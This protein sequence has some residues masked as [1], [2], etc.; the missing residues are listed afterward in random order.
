MMLQTVTTSYHRKSIV[1]CSQGD[2][3]RVFDERKIKSW[4]KKGTINFR[5]QV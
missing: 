1:F 2:V 3:G 4:K 5:A